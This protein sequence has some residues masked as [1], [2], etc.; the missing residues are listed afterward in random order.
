MRFK[1]AVLL[2]LL[3][4]VG[5]AVRPGTQGLAP[6]AL[7]SFAGS[8]SLLRPEQASLVDDWARRITQA[9]G[10]TIDPVAAYDSLP[11]SQRTTFNAVTHALM[12][13]TLTSAD[14]RALAPTA[15]GIVAKVDAVHGS[16]P[17]ARGDLQ[18][19]LYVQLAPDALA[20]LDAS[21]EFGRAMD[22]TVYHKGYPICYRSQGTPS[23]QVSISRDGTLSDIDVDYR[24][25]KFPAFL[26]NGHLTAANSDVRAGNNDERHNNRWTGLSNW[27]QNLLGL[28]SPAAEADAE[29]KA[30]PIATQ[31]R[32]PKGSKPEAAVRD[33]LS[34][35]L[36]DGRPGDAVPY[37]GDE[38]IACMQL[39]SGTPIDRGVVRVEVLV[40]LHQ[41]SQEMGPVASLSDAVTAADLPGTQSRL[42]QQPNAD[43]TLYDVREDEAEHAKCSSRLDPTHVDR[44]ALTSTSYGKY[45]A[46][47]F[48]MKKGP[49]AGTKIVSL[50]RQYDGYWRIVSYMD[51]EG[52]DRVMELALRK[53]DAPAPPLVDADAVLHQAAL[54]FATQWFVTR[55]LDRAIAYMA[56]AAFGCINNFL[57][58]G[59][60]PASGDVQQRARVRLGM[61]AVLDI[62]GPARTLTQAIAAPEVSHPDVKLVRQN[63]SSAFALVSIPDGMFGGCGAQQ[64]D[65]GR[66]G[67][68][69]SH[70]TYYASGFRLATTVEE[71]AVAWFVWK[72]IGRSWR[73]V[74]F[75]IITP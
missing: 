2:C 71:P 24:S 19:R 25:S 43:F 66:Q 26:F 74:G 70:G 37:F 27:W 67:G 47:V 30:S 29:A 9:A 10:R 49:R 7:P 4:L 75:D 58:D 60:A 63:A 34:A 48:Q 15:L 46:A 64:T 33:F 32:V 45:V 51:E 57:E 1:T 35:W 62:A 16:I 6:S 22:N 5:F 41:R 8:Y 54:D 13:T 65:E 68:S 40:G 50:W 20:R 69:L 73:I 23:I 39:E 11:L 59:E 18:F 28:F 17:D 21:R 36:V 14:G 53:P 61:Q 72:K 55:H 42:R 44:R 38:S 52:L 12:R 56:P 3:S 31:P